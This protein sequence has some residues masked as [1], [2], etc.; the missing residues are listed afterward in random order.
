MRLFDTVLITAS[1][2]RQARSFRALLDRRR[3][4]G[5]YPREIDF[6]VVADPPA[7]RVGTGGGTLWALEK[8]LEARGARD[9]AAFFGSQRILLIHA[10]GESRRMPAYAPEGKLF[11][12][13]PLASSALLPPVVLD[14]Q[15]G[16]F[17]EYPWRKG[18]IVVSTGDVVIDFDASGVPEERGPVFGFAKPAS[19][20]QGSRHGVFRFDPHREKVVDYL[21]K[22][23][24]DV[25]ARSARIEGTGE[26]ALDIG[27]VSLAP[28]AAL[29]FLELGRTPLGPATL[30][31]A[32]SR[33]RLRFDLY[34]E[35]LTACLPGLFFEGFWDRVRSASALP[36]DLARRV[37]EAFHRFGLG[38]TV[39]RST[40]FEHV[41]SLA[42]LPAAC[43]GVLA[44][45]V[46]PFYEP[47]GGRTRPPTA[48]SRTAWASR[49][50]SP[51]RRRSSWTRAARARS[52]SPATTS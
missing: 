14:A 23:P 44:R 5:L 31:E 35:V 25:L 52:P 33:G 15:L 22:A 11:A 9:P 48:S 3:E 32:L 42:E 49:S 4:R 16:L 38:G 45:S 50:R 6:E 18:E 13:L 8:L 34:L 2:E 7:G 29:A 40:F 43:R 27:L 24:A 10:G 47:E 26:C 17:L 46:A 51:G 20:E 1:S 30:L 36:E 28:E 12:P 21:Q 39:T 41:G 37:Y 19:F